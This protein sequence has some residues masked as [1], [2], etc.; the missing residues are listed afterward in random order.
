MMNLLK[1][2]GCP[3]CGLLFGQHRLTCSSFQR[4]QAGFTL[5]E[6]MIVVAIIGILAAIA[7]PA[8]QNY[9][10]RAQVT[11][12]QTLATTLEV[13][14][15][16]FFNTNGVMP[17][18]LIELCSGQV[19]NTTA[20]CDLASNHQ[21][22]YVSSVDVVTGNIVVTFG[23][24]TA[25]QNILN[26]QLVFT[27]LANTGGDVSWG[28]TGNTAYS[29]AGGGPSLAQGVAAVAAAPAIQPQFLPK[30]CQQT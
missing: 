5:I 13:K 2:K 19:G 14:A 27:P 21:G 17:Q 29:T 11:E 22:K 1:V 12:G 3:G 25:N 15:D 18:T 8:Y 26:D 7:I 4:K 20:T 9:T 10:I 6:L 23:M 16:E 30:N 28:C 24:P